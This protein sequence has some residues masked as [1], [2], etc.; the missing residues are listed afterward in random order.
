MLACSLQSNFRTSSRY[1]LD[2]IACSLIKAG[3]VTQGGKI[4]R[5]V[6]NTGVE[7]FAFMGVEK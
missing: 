3:G 6:V 5:D 4:E 7:K 2:T 1:L